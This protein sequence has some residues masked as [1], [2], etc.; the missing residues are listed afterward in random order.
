MEKPSSGYELARRFDKSIGHFWHA[1][2]QQIYRVLARMEEAG[3]IASEVQRGETAPDRRVF[4]L[5]KDGRQAVSTWLTEDT[6]VDSI[7]S[8]LMIKFRAAAFD[9]PQ[10]LIPE[11][12]THLTQHEGVL[13]EYRQ[14][15]ARDFSGVLSPQQALQ[16]HV[17]K[18]GIVSEQNWMTWCKE[19]LDL[20]GRL[21]SKPN[22]K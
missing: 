7:R 12:R 6:P 11:L 4:T 10:R 3:W 18:L 19:A 20:V 5:T 8:T 15:E 13:D 21:S 16:Y 2:H 22:T 1:T 9:D 14:I 17:L